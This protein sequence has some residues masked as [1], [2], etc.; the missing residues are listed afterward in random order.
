MVGGLTYL[1]IGLVA[2]CGLSGLLAMYR[3]LTREV[4][5]ILS[6]AFAAAATL[7]FVLYQRQVAIDL[8]QQYGQ[9]KTVVQIAL[10]VI[11]FVVVLLIVHFITVRVSDGILDS[12]V[13]IIDRVLGFVFG[14]VRGF[15]LVVI[16]YL[17]FAFMADEKTHPVWIREASFLPVIK[18]TGESIKNV[19][20]DVVPANFKLPGTGTETTGGEGTGA[21]GTGTEPAAPAPGDQQQ[22]ATQDGGQSG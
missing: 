7:Y 2:I 11:I 3:G 9:S 10:G 15:L 19:L 12:R 1:D 17:F 22:P 20:V 18:S 5:S 13:G 4:L 16:A 21:E 8:A 14:I 6:W